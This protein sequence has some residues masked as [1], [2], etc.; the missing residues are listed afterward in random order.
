MFRIAE[1]S[2]LPALLH[3][4]PWPAFHLD[5]LFNRDASI[6][7]REGAAG[8]STGLYL[9][10]RYFEGPFPAR[11]VCGLDDLVLHTLMLHDK[12]NERRVPLVA[13]HKDTR[14]RGHGENFA[15]T[16]ASGQTADGGL[17]LEYLF[18]KRSVEHHNGQGRGRFC[19]GRTCEFH[20]PAGK[21]RAYGLH[22]RRSRR[23]LGHWRH[24]RNDSN[25]SA[26]WRR[27]RGRPALMHR[28]QTYR[29]QIAYTGA[30]FYCGSFGCLSQAL[31]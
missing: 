18:P 2:D 29:P 30:V 17:I 6:E 10:A 15:L 22:V 11:R 5:R 14:Q 4:R 9:L 3:R 21:H 25:A 31:W 16:S 24:A 20:G 27:C 8:R 12:D 1:D 7:D 13:T 19:R 23:E 26:F 28:Q